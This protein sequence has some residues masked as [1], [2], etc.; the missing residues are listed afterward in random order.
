MRVN[1]LGAINVARACARLDA[2]CVRISTDYVFGGQD[3]GLYT[4]EDP[5]SRS[6]STACPNSPASTLRWPI[7]RVAGLFGTTQARAKKRTF[8]EA[9]LA[10]AETGEDIMVV[11]DRY[12]EDLIGTTCGGRQRDEVGPKRVAPGAEAVVPPIIGSDDSPESFERTKVGTSGVGNERA[13]AR[14]LGNNT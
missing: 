14:Q 10:R 8:V 13:G 4:E 12:V 9:I 5:P 3:H 1:A 6:M 2:V 7:V 11:D